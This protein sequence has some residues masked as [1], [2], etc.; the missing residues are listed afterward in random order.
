MPIKRQIVFEV[1]LLALCVYAWQMAEAYENVAFAVLFGISS[2]FVS[3]LILRK[4]KPPFFKAFALLTLAF[5]FFL[6]S[7]WRVAI[8]DDRVIAPFLI[9]L[10]APTLYAVVRRENPMWTLIASFVPAGVAAGAINL[11]VVLIDLSTAEEAVASPVVYSPIALGLILSYACRLLAPPHEYKPET[12]GVIGFFICFLVTGFSLTYYLVYFVE[13]AL[14]LL[15]I[16]AI[17]SLYAVILCCFAFNDKAQLSV[18]EVMAQ[19]GLFACLLGAVSLVTLYTAAVVTNDAKLIGPVM[20]SPQILML[21]GAMTIIAA[22]A[23]GV[24][25][26]TDRELITRDWHITEAY[27]FISL[28]VFPPLTLLEQLNSQL[29]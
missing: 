24:R 5:I 14:I 1:L 12:T 6:N 17:L 29:G 13:G 2:L 10:I 7:W 9:L 11:T 20:A 23:C 22:S 8:F 21:Y 16:Y 15:N 28:V 18:G 19:A 26:P 4:T 3:T 25:A 27:V